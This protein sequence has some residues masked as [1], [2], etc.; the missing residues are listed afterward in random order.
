MIPGSGFERYCGE[1]VYLGFAVDVY[2]N[3]DED[4]VN[5]EVDEMD[6]SNNVAWTMNKVTVTGM[7]CGNNVDVGAG[8]KQCK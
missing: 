1:S 8:E 4:G 2:D 5:G 7:Q 3:D 6:E